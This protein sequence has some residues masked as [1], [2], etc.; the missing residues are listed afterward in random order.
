MYVC[1]LCC[2]VMFIFVSVSHYLHFIYLACKEKKIR[3]QHRDTGK[4]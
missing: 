1:V 2:I 4:V 3:E